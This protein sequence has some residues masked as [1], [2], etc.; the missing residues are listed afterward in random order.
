MATKISK[1]WKGRVQ[2]DEEKAAK[3]AAQYSERQ[4]DLYRR[5]YRRIEKELN[6][7]FADMQSGKVTR[8][9]LWNYYRY[10]KILDIISGECKSIG[11][12]QISLMDELA[13]KL[14]AEVIGKTLTEFDKQSILS[15]LNM[16]QLMA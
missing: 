13:E 6:A 16:E 7:I 4:Q 12:Y 15:G 9:M 10:Q 11:G 1:Y 2:R 14:F 5:A 3:L 8:T